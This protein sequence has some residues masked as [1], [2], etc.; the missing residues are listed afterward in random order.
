MLHS[1]RHRRRDLAI[2]LLITG[3]PFFVLYLS[4]R[5]GNRRHPAGKLAVSATAPLQLVVANVFGGLA[6]LFHDYLVLTD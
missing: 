6:D 4:T 2:I 5:P 1:S 3:L